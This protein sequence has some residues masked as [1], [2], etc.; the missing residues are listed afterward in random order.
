MHTRSLRL[1]LSVGVVA[2]LG[3][4]GCN[5]QNRP[6]S[7]QEFEKA[8]ADAQAKQEALSRYKFSYADGIDICYKQIRQKLGDQAM[9]NAIESIFDDTDNN[10]TKRSSPALSVCTV[11]YQDPSN[12][13]QLLSQAMNTNTGK[14]EAARPM[15][16]RILNNPE[17]F[18]LESIL[19]PIQSI[20]PL[21]V[22]EQIERDKSKLDD[23]LTD[24]TVHYLS[25]ND[26][27][28]LGGNHQLSLNIVG[29]FKA[30]ETKA[31][32]MMQFSPDGKTLLSS[33]LNR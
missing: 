3:L 15:E 19:L 9:I 29:K 33:D 20:N 28:P 13:K 32:I 27:G 18:K 1:V 22:A 4:V 10:G 2:I 14:F 23:K 16:L 30:N 12:P 6:M 5:S 31:S 25:L 11:Q 8:M 17:A 7:N 21:A 24:Y 26:G